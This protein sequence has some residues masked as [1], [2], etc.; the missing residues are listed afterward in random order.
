LIS[1]AD[2]YENGDTIT[3]SINESE[4]DAI[5]TWDQVVTVNDTA[6]GKPQSLWTAGVFSESVSTM[7]TV[8]AGDHG[9]SDTGDF[10]ITFDATAFGGAFYISATSTSA[11]SYHVEDSNGNPATGSSTAAVTS[12]ATRENDAYRIN[13]GETQTFKLELMFAPSVPGDYRA[14]LDS[15]A[16]GDSVALPYGW[17][18]PATPDEDFETPNIHLTIATVP[19]IS[20][21]HTDRSLTA[22]AVDGVSVPN[23]ASSTFSYNVELPAG[24]THIPTVTATA[25]DESMAVTITQAP[26]FRVPLT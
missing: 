25:T 19:P 24:T 1:K 21:S 11:F 3:A 14:E 2:N 22:L 17:D 9:A 15:I 23:F 8:I 18:S 4:R 12:T 26:P 5:V 10:E 7:A 6:V 16:F 13:D 20:A